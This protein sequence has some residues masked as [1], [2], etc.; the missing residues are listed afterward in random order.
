[1]GLERTIHLN[2]DAHPR[3]L[4][5]RRAGH[6]IGRWDGDTLSWTRSDSSRAFCSPDGRVPHSGQMHVIERFTLEAD[7]RTLR[8]SFVATDPLYFEGEH[9]GG[10]AVYVADVPYQPIACDDQSSKAPHERPGR[11][12]VSPWVLVGV[13]ALGLI[14]GIV[15]WRR[16]RAPPAT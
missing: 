3:D 14:V 5:P 2:V 12:W 7:G 11:P 10:D 9:R 8:R 4:T 15:V 1:M 13:T 16:S 6:S